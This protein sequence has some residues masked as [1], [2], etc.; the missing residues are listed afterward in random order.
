[1]MQLLNLYWLKLNA[2]PEKMD[3]VA[4]IIVDDLYQE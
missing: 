3:D 1:M 4:L 2:L